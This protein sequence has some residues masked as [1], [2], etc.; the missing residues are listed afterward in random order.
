MSLIVFPY[1]P[2]F[3]YRQQRYIIF[4]ISILFL[5]IFFVSP[6]IELFLCGFL[7][8]FAHTKRIICYNKIISCG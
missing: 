4:T 3:E 1:V 5:S 6:L 7:F 2:M 8:T